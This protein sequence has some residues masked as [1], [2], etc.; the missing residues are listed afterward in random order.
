[1][2][3]L[4][5]EMLPAGVATLL[6]G[7]D[8]TTVQRAGFKGLTNG[9]LIRRAALSG[10][11]VLLTSDASIPAQQ[12]LKAS[13]IAVVVVRGSRM[14]DLVGQALRIKEAIESAV[15]NAVIRIERD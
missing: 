6:D 2:R 8:V 9:E 11:D 3:V 15:P 1:M 7:H 14:A 13:D 10:Y 4:L 5:D 12:N